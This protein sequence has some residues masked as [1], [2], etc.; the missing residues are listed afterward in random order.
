MQGGSASSGKHER[1]RIDGDHRRQSRTKTMAWRRCR[2]SRG[3]WLGGEEEGGAAE[4]LSSAEGRG[5]AG[6]GCYGK[7]RRWWCS[8]VRERERGREG[9]SRARV[10]E[11]RGEG[12]ASSGASRRGG[13]G[14]QAGEQVAWRGGARARRPHSPPSVE[15][16]D[17]RGGRRA[18][19]PTGWAGQLDGLHREE[20]R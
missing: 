12:V 6:D 7:R 15:D 10:R 20:P 11:S 16:E 19:P 1:R 5:V 4:L 2:A 17:D 18:G 13:E 8:A 9:E 14:R 3:A